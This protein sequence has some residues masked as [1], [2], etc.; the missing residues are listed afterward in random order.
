MDVGLHLLDVVRFLFGEADRLYCRTA[1]IDP[2]VRGEDTATMLLDHVGGVTSVVELST[3]TK[4]HPEPFPETLVRIEGT[5]GTIE[6]LQDYRLVLTRP[7][8]REE[9]GV[10]AEVLPWASRPWHVVQDSVLAIQRHWVEC[11]REGSPPATSGADNLKTLELTYAAY[12]SA[13]TGQAAA[14]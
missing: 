3:A 11:L 2:R 8:T 13:E 1:R 14:F 7:G 4:T 12:R 5:E 10:D 9:R 6:L